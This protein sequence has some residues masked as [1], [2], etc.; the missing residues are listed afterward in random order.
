MDLQ[1]DLLDNDMAVRQ[2]RERTEQ[3]TD[4]VVT[5]DS[6]EELMAALMRRFHSAP[7]NLDET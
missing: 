2:M 4:T 5:F 3:T 6:N 1:C 7:I